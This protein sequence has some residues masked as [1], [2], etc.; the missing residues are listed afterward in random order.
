MNRMLVWTGLAA[1][2]ALAGAMAAAQDNGLWIDPRCQPLDITKLG[3]F[4]QNDDGSLLM[5]DKNILRTSTDG[6]KTWSEGGD[7]IDPGINITP[8]GHVGQ[9]LRTKDGALVILF[10]DHTKYVFAWDDEKNAPKPECILE[11]WSIR[12]TDGG[13]TWSDKQRLLDGYNA[14]FMGFIQLKSG[15][16]VATVEHLDPELCRWLG[17]SFVSDDEGRTW[18]RSNW[19]DLGGRGNHDGT[20]EPAVIEQNDGRLMMFIRTNMD[21]IWAAWS[22]DQGRN[23][24]VIQPTDIEASSAPAWVTRLRSGRLM[25]AWNPLHPEGRDWP[26][27]GNRSMTERPA[28]WYRE[29]VCVAFSDDDAKTWTKPVVVARYPGK[30]LAYPYI[31]ERAPGEAWVMTYYGDP[32]LAIKLNDKDFAPTPQP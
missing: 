3:P 16:L 18:T 31:F 19:I 9:F 29:E 13:K 8:N 6:G 23:W 22:E 15:R 17:C 4:L 5:V 25:M 2:L 27:G 1:T 32:H 11:L 30:S 10:L 26:K 7:V 20:L 12:S 24:R 21:R 28:S 14:D